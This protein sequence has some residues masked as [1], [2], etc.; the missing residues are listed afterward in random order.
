MTRKFLPTLMI[1]AESQCLI[2]S[3]TCNTSADNNICF[4]VGKNFLFRRL[5][6]DDL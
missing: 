2:V 1:A 5:V 4:L 3:F 6:D